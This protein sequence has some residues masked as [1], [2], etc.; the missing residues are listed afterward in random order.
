MPTLLNVSANAK[1]VKS[2]KVGQLTGILYLAPTT[3]SGYNTCSFASNGCKIACLNTAG[4]GVFDMV[5]A[6]RIRKTKM[7]FE[8]RAAFMAELIKD[9]EAL[10]R[11]AK[12]EN[13][14]PSLRLNGTSDIKWEK[15]SCGCHKNI[16]E[17]FPSIIAYDYTKIPIR[18][19][20][21]LPENSSLPCALNES[22]LN[23]A[24]EALAMGTNVAA[25]FRLDHLGN[26][27]EFFHGYRVIDGDKYDARYLD[28][29]GV[30][31]GLKAKGAA[32]K[33]TS[34]FVY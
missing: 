33:D 25:V 24:L 18:Y 12:R 31:V 27:P 4:R 11:K 30:V 22:N 28:A 1:T 5:Q 6:A 15:I 19:R 3:M 14:V 32:I 8:N 17:H 21:N 2:E 29:T 10:I 9:I 20:Q 16:F 7:F 26:L 13:L 23:E 34:G